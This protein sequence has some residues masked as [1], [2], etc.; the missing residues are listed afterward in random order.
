VSQES[1]K[2]IVK[3]SSPSTFSQ[4]KIDIHVSCIAGS[5]NIDCQ[6]T[7]ATQKSTWVESPGSFIDSQSA[8][9]QPTANNFDDQDNQNQSKSR[10]MNEL[11]SQCLIFGKIMIPVAIISL[12]M[13]GLYAI[14]SWV[15]P[16]VLCKTYAED[17]SV[18]FQFFGWLFTLINSR[19][20]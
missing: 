5:E 18:G 12:W 7:L 14:L 15:I 19:L 20:L 2:E 3:S 16:S 17:L 6:D 8:S 13:F 1:G 10:W 9:V 11:K 4:D